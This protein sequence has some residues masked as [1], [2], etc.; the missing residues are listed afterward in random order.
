MLPNQNIDL[1]LQDRSFLSKVHFFLMDHIKPQLTMFLS[2]GA[3]QSDS[4]NITQIGDYCLAWRQK[5]TRR[6]LGS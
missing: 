3:L 2:A 5:L 4:W 1:S 6:Q